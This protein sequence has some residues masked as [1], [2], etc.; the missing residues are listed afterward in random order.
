[1]LVAM[2]KSGQ[3]KVKPRH[4][5]PPDVSITLSQ[6]R[7]KQ[8]EALLAQHNREAVKVLNIKIVMV[9]AS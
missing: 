4:Q 7:S 8:M 1:M 3:T 2:A 5:E 9:L 6:P